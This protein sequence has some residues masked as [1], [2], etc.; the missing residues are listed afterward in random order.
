MGKAT[1]DVRYTP[2]AGP[3]AFSNPMVHARLNTYSEMG[4]QKHGPEWDPVVQPLDGEVVMRMG[5]GKRHGRYAIG[6]STIDTASTPTL[7]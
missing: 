4:R 5:G 6:D 1:S 2:E 7:S 3:E